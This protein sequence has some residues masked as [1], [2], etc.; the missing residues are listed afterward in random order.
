MTNGSLPNLVKI[1]LPL[2]KS[3]HDDAL[4]QSSFHAPV[5]VENILIVYGKMNLMV[6]L[7][8]FAQH[9]KE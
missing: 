4:L 5:A 6:T 7:I 9:S 1:I 8:F 2:K 3:M